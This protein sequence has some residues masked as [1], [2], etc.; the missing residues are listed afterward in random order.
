MK[1]I[2]II[3]AV[4]VCGHTFAQNQAANWFFGQGAGINFDIASGAVSSVDTGQLNTLEGCTSISDNTGNLVLYTDGRT[5][6]NRNHQVMLN[7]TGLFGDPSSTQSAL[8]VPAPKDPNK[9]YIFTVDT[10]INPNSDP[11]NG[12]NY[13]IV[14]MSLNG[15]LGGITSK[16][17]PLLVDSTEKI[18]AVLKD[19]QSESIWVLTFASFDGS[20]EFFNTYH[21]FEVSTTGVNPTSVV[22]SF[23]PIP[24]SDPRGQIKVSPDGTKLISANVVGGTY[25]YDFDALTGIVSNELELTINSPSP[26]AYGVEFSPSSELLYVHSYNNETFNGPASIHQST[27]TQFNLTS[28]DIQASEF[29]VDQR[30]LYRGSLQ[31]GPNGKIYRALSS[32]YPNGLP[33][34][35]VINNPNAIGAACNYQHNAINLSPNL[36]TQGLP[37]FIQSFFN[38]QIDIIQNGTSTSDLKLCTGDTYTLSYEDIP[39]AIYTWSKDG[40]LLS[41]SDFDLDIIEGGTY[42]L[43]IEFNNGSCDTFEGIAYVS[44]HEIPFANQANHVVVCDDNNNNQ[45]VF[46]FTAQDV[47]VLGLQDSN[48]FSVHYFSS[49]TDANNNV[50]EIIGSYNNNT[51]PQEIFARIHNRENPN[52]YDL[53]SF[54]VEV[55][56]TPVANLIGNLEICDDDNDGDAMN[57]QRNFDLTTLNSTVL[58]NQNALSNSIT[59]HISQADADSNNNALPNIYYNITPFTEEIFVRIE[60]N[61]NTDCYS[62]ISFNLIIN[63]IPEAF[64]ATLFQCDEDGNP[65]GF[66][67]FN[68]TEA[69]DALSGGNSNRTTKFYLTLLDAENDINEIDG[70]SFNNTVNPQIIFVRVIN[71]FTDCHN[72][73]LLMLDVTATDANDAIIEKCDNDGIEDGF[74]NFNLNEADA[75]ILNGLPATVTL[76]YYETYEDSLLEQN[77][78]SIPYTNTIS[79]LQTIFA[80]VENDNACYGITEIQLIVYELP[81]IETE[82]ETLYCLN[83]FPESIPL[84]SGLINNI[85]TDFTYSWSTGETTQEIL[86][87]APGTY[88][89]T[90][91]NANSCTKLRTITVLPSNTATFENIEVTDATSNNIISILVSGE[92]DYEFSLNE[93]GGPYQDSNLFEN[94]PPG[95]HT[96]YVRDK[97]DCGIVSEIVS[98]IGFPK[99]FTPNGDSYND[100]WH[101]YGIND[102]SQFKSE[103]FIYDR[104]GKLIKQLSPQGSGWD[105]TFNGQDLPTNDYWFHVKLQ[106]GRVFKSH[107][108]LKR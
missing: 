54:F 72:I 36:S 33:F 41:E 35:G 2:L 80:R 101:V 100:T 98:V 47:D 87:N 89:V 53:T 83:T 105:G 28:P 81:N 12:F 45:W 86:I 18:T 74:Y 88:T 9:Y 21:A 6:Y 78:L 94:V 50:N 32:N 95:L 16:N 20:V 107:F 99:F 71:A 8:V 30:Q 91:S 15:G 108:S 68:L 93:I 65:D 77:A 90:V 10:T 97:N 56:D 104:Y 22:S 60:N 38:D 7:G 34:L 75:T 27:L 51:N 66:T 46:D 24:G 85:P 48:V 84:N 4:L 43:L 40:V 11:D 70:N 62:T 14:D 39:N 76:S 59:Y 69:N 13:S 5:V 1:K 61:L 29:A 49:Q 96:V 57:G 26:F 106:D 52:C 92:G 23:A 55:F 79:Y 103:V 25:L 102:I 3:L 31:L 37:P 67:L 64:D 42:E 63:Q 58:G 17:V 82:F 19:C 73:S 44:Y